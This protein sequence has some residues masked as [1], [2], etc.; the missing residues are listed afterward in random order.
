M[1]LNKLL[2]VII[3][4]AVLL[5]FQSTVLA[6]D[7]NNTSS[8][9]T[10]PYIYPTIPGTD[11]W[12]ALKTHQ[13]KID[14][15]QIPEN[16]LKKMTT[17]ALIETVLMYPLRVD[18][19][20]WDTF[21][22]GFQNVCQQFNGLRELSA[23]VDA[24]QKLSYMNSNTLAL[25]DV[26]NNLEPLYAKVIMDGIS[27]QNGQEVEHRL[28]LPAYISTYV[29]TP[30][31]NPVPVY[32]D[33]TWADHGITAEQANQYFNDLLLTY[34]YAIKKTDCSPAYNCHSYAWYSTSTSN[35]YW[36]DDPTTYMT[37]NSYISST[38]AASGRRVYYN[39]PGGVY[40]DH[41]GIVYSV[42]SGFVGV[43]SKWGW[44]G[45]VEHNVYDCPYAGS[46]T[47]YTYWY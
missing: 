36:M 26:S 31:N 20:A 24:L 3:T 6:T 13:E 10:K 42:Y 43:R 7:L 2:L 35:R 23:R 21:D 4:I 18:M 41:S 37:D 39:N 22:I 45:V 30:E 33:L 9:I 17:E 16:I 34:P 25:V 44:A 8:A 19:L 32:Q 5:S 40:D 38:A 29:S 46:S 47:A 12:C 27:K 11:E 14:V 15:C 1:K 28:I